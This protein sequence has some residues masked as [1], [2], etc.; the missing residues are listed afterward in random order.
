MSA[1]N[2][3]ISERIGPSKRKFEDKHPLAGKKP[4]TR[5]EKPIVSER[6]KLKPRPI[7]IHETK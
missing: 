3:N 1:I 4:T 7:R 2:E 6:I 5:K